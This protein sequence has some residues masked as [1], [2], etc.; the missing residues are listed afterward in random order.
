L[1]QCCHLIR[2]KN[3]KRKREKEGKCKT[4]MKK[5]ERKGKKGDRK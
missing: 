2:G 1:A 4:K 3:M 5:E